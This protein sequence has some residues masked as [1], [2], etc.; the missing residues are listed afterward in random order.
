CARTSSP[1]GV[2][3]GT[4]SA[5]A[6]AIAGLV[7]L[8]GEPTRRGEVGD[9]AVAVVGHVLGELHP[10]GLE[11]GHRAVD[12]IAVE[13]DI[14]RPG[15]TGILHRVHAEVPLREVEDPPPLADVGT[16]KADLVP[17]EGTRVLGGG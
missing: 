4:A 12:V 1:S 9:Q 10:A 16:R 2:V 13:G 14:V 17:E 11:V 6:L 3:P 8:D 15:V 5:S 7:E